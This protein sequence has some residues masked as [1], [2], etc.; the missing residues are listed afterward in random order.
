MSRFTKRLIFT[1]LSLT[2]LC[3]A[4]SVPKDVAY[5]QDLSSDVVIASAKKQPIRVK[6]DDRLSIIV[7]TKDPKLSELFNLPVYSNRI[8]ETTTAGDVACYMVNSDGDIDFPILGSLHVEGMNRSELA[9]FIKGELMGRE[10]VKEPTVIVDFVNSGVSVMGEVN[11]P[12]RYDMKHDNLNILEALALAGDLSIN[13]QRKNVK[14][15]REENG[16]LHTYVL[17][18]TDASG[19]VKSPGFHLQQNDVVY[20]E[21]DKIKKRSTNVNGNTLS[22]VGFWMS[23]ASVLAAVVTTIAVFVNK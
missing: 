13:G 3:G 7:K 22:S 12:G 11:K 21:P 2:F 5:M 6:P 19:M 18:L 16:E 23:L 4:C 17:D 20:V 1:F 15:I 14:V 9:G 8:G 10:L